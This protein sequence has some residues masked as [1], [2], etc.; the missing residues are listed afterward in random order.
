MR[1]VKCPVAATASVGYGDVGFPRSG[2]M[3]EE[4]DGLAFGPKVLQGG[5]GFALMAVESQFGALLHREETILIERTG[6]NLALQKQAQL[7]NDT[8][9][10]VGE[11]HVG[12]TVDL[13]ALPDE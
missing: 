13:P 5:E 12:P 4:G 8:I 6:G 3:R 7:F 10:F 1:E 9:P 2:G 11:L